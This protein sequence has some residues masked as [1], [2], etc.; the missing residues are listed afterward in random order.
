MVSW[1]TDVNSE[2]VLAKDRLDLIVTGRNVFEM[3]SQEG[4]KL[5]L[6]VK[7]DKKYATK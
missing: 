7:G 6:K 5:N 2:G 4:F 3:S 1:T